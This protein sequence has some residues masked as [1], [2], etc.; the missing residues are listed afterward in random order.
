MM[1]SLQLLMQRA[2]IGTL[3]GDRVAKDKGEADYANIPL[4]QEQVL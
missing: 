3:F 4:D 1:Q 2:L